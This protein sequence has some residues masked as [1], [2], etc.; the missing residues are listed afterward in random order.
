MKTSTVVM[1]CVFVF[2]NICAQQKLP[3]IKAN[4]KN[5]KILDGKNF[6]PN[7]WVVFPETKPDIYYLDLPKKAQKIKF[8]TDIEEITFDMKFGETK[9]FIVLLNG[10]DSCYTRISANYPLL[11]TYKKNKKGNDTIP[12]TMKNNRIYFQGKINGSEVL[13]FQFDLG[14]DAVNIN[15]KSV[16]KI[17]IDFDK[18]GNL[19]NSDGINE[20]RVSST[21]T[22]EISGLTWSNIEMYETKNMNNYEDAIIGNSFFLDKIYKIDYDKQIIVVYD[23]MPKI[24][25]DF[26]KQDMLLDNG[27]RPVF[28]AMFDID[29]KKYKDWFLFDTGNTGNGI[30]GNGFLTRNDLYDK[31]SNLVGLGS[32]KIAF[33]PKLI[34][35]NQSISDGVIILE[36][37]KQKRIAIQI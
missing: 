16:K 11:K 7:F 9:D 26:V 15:K 2:Q 33:I 37:T 27:V 13:N 1:F 23:E 32:K 21:N 6:K 34:I 17:N 8:I 12:I 19:I 30:V 18:K 5:V 25:A 24:D 28:E 4:S 36:K 35:A 10:K 14:A 3:I 22:F 20:T 29:G 31:F